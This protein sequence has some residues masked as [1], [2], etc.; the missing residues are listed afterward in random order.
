MA[1]SPVDMSP[2]ALERRLR[3]LSQLW[4]FWVKIRAAQRADP[5]EQLGTKKPDDE[6]TENHR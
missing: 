3:E 5:V 2:E 4:K 1:E 6:S